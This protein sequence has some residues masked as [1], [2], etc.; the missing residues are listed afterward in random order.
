MPRSP[1]SKP[2]TSSPTFNRAK[3]QLASIVMSDYSDG[4]DS[5]TYD[6]DIESSTTAVREPHRASG[7]HHSSSSV[8]TLNSVHISSATTTP[9]N[10]NDPCNGSINPL[11]AP[12]LVTEEPP[13]PE[14]TQNTIN[15]AALSVQDIRSFVQKAIDG[16]SFR[17]YKI[18]PPPV[19]RPVRVYADGEQENVIL[20]RTCADNLFRGIRS[21]PFW[22]SYP[23][24]YTASHL[25]PRSLV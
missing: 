18:N 12:L 6:G 5:P 21:V 4:V 15:P 20:E 23:L 2:P 16:E 8:S 3:H 14:P 24:G 25:I 19:G 1:V 13:V 17:K 7:H 11:A 10:E 22:V 9:L